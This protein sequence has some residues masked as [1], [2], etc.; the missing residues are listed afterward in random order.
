MSISYVNI[1]DKNGRP[2]LSLCKPDLAHTKI[3]NLT[4][5]YDAEIT[6]NL[7]ALNELSFSMPIY[8]ERDKQRVKNPLIEK[9]NGM[10]HVRSEWNGRTE[11]F[12]YTKGNRKLS[13]SGKEYQYKLLSIGHLLSKKIIRSYE[14][15]SKSL[16]W[17]VVEF[18][19]ESDWFIG[20]VDADFDLI[21]RSYETTESTV[22][23]AIFDI[24][25]KFGALVQW[26]TVNQ[27][28]N[29]MKPKN[30]GKNKGFKIRE[31]VFLES[32][33]AE[34]NYDEIVT[35]L[36][37][38]GEDGMEFRRLSPTGSNY[39]E[40]FDWYMHPF[41]CDSNYNVLKSSKYMSDELCV[42]IRKYEKKVADSNPQFKTYTT[43]KTAKEDEIQQREQELSVLETEL[44]VILNERDVINATYMDEAPLRS[45]WQNV[46]AR[47][48]SKEAQI[49]SKKSVITSLKLQLDGIN[50]Q[51]NTLRESLKVDNNYT[52]V[53]LREMNKFI[54]SKTYTNSSISN[55]QDLL[56]EGAKVF[57]QY[58]V[59]P[60]SLNIS[61]VNFL[62]DFEFDNIKDRIAIGDTVTAKLQDLDLELSMKINQIKYNFESDSISLTVTNLKDLRDD[63]Q[64][65]L[66]T[67]YTANN[68]SATVDMGKHLWDNVTNVESTIDKILNSEYDTAKNILTGGYEGSTV[69]NSRGIYSRDLHNPDTLLAINMGML[70]I[71][72]DN[73]NTI[74]VAISKNGVHAER[75]VGKIIL[76][77][78]LW[79][80]DELGVVEIQSGLQTI[81]DQY[82]VPRVYLGRYPTFA[83]PNQFDYGLRIVNGS[84]DIRTS[85]STN[86]GVVITGEGISAYN[87]NKVR[88]FHVDAKTGKVSIVGSLDIRSS[89][90]AYKGV[91]IDDSGIKIYGNSGQIV[92]HADHYGNVTF[93]GRLDG[94]T[95]TVSNL[96]GT[97]NNMGGSYVGSINS[98]GTFRGLT[99]GTL[100]AQTVDTIRLKAEQ[101][102]TGKLS[103][104]VIDTQSLSAA[105]IEVDQLRANGIQVNDL[106]AISSNL[107]NITGGNIDITESISIGDGIYLKGGMTGIYFPT[108][109]QIFD[110]GGS[111][112]VE[113]FNILHLVGGAGRIEMWGDVHIHGALTGG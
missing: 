53:Q 102:T 60:T 47:K 20:Y 14:E 12:V 45:D 44:N 113:A 18:L 56:D 82:G 27:K 10:Y 85:S 31:G 104:N 43:N 76:S 29:F 110:A 2:K 42:A 111:L 74:S 112:T 66:S 6:I 28:I 57:K 15:T 70:F 50:N 107:G 92:F 62:N 103:A 71:T 68:T 95:G 30:S 34:I 37:V 63:W 99:T 61:L 109:S 48:N 69:I 90:D 54:N 96:G 19:K 5:I 38:Y 81:Y 21:K 73:G 35:R 98:D 4:D 7:G 72:P 33:D 25:E 84:F 67:I 59:P 108:W 79:V 17:F 24:A 83:N 75:L 3:G 86:M 13:S 26:D 22:L 93:R 94:A 52:S 87:N 105:T 23:Q 106:S 39:I 58:N 97:I 32:L 91:V 49:A 36:Y 64:K 1:N 9:F 55:E 77:K 80:E 46:I 41:E 65:F 16:T 78:K 40:S 88:T 11:Y 101:I 51:I 100:S 8:V 89:P